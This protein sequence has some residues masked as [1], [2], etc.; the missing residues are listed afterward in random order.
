MPATTHSHA[1]GQD[2]EFEPPKK[3][4]ASK[5]EAAKHQG[6]TSVCGTISLK[7]L[8][9]KMWFVVDSTVRLESIMYLWTG[10]RKLAHHRPLWRSQVCC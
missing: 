1:H 5:A 6:F 8:S 4:F 9:L 3:P 10:M 2:P 7:M